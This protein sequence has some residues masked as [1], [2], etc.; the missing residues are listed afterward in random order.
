M[1]ESSDARPAWAN[2]R[3]ITIVAGNIPIMTT[4]TERSAGRSSLPGS[5]SLP[6]IASAAKRQSAQSPMRAQL[7]QFGGIDPSAILST[8]QLIPQI[9]RQNAN[10]P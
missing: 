3:P 1:N 4:P 5:L 9:G 10:S 7:S 6:R 8:G 2:S